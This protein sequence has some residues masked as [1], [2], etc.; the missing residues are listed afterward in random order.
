MESQIP[1][2]PRVSVVIPTFNRRHVLGRALDSVRAQTRAPDEVI[3]VDDGSTDGT[4]DWLERAYPDIVVLRQPNRGVSSAR[5]LGIDAASGLYIA[6]LDSDDAWHPSK[7]E[8]QMSILSPEVGQRIA[9]TEEVWI[10]N[11][12]QVNPMKKHA[13]SG[14][15]LFEKS[16]GLCCISPSA[17]VMHRS[18]FHDYGRFDEKL[19]ACE[20][21]DLWLRI[22]A[23]EPL[24]FDD[25]AMTI[26]YGGHEDQLSRKY[27]GMDRFRIRA[28]ENLMAHDELD[29]RCRKQALHMLVKKLQI[30]VNGAQKRNNERVITDYEPKL[31]RW[32]SVLDT[33]VST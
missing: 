25:N 31:N 9:H 2:R 33:E 13:K 22:T 15:W 6:F 29:S 10:R 8:R 16:L 5:N 14:G 17:V 11:G 20:D 7:L 19:P 27:W 12:R 18:V 1:Q 23:Y 3:V 28:L 30:L 26:K 24:L 4:V 32:Q 21:Y